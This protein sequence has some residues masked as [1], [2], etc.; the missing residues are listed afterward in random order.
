MFQFLK[1]TNS[2]GKLLY[3]AVKVE[4]IHLKLQ[5]IPPFSSLQL[6]KIES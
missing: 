5:K 6:K 3:D 2:Y 1:G 4:K